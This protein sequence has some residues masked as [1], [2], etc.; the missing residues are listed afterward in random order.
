MNKTTELGNI[1]WVVWLGI[2]SSITAIITF[3]SGK[4]LP[5]FFAKEENATS[6]P[7]VLIVQPTSP[8]ITLSA[9]DFPMP[10]SVSTVTQSPFFDLTGVWNL[11]LEYEGYT[12][13][14]GIYKERD[15]PVLEKWVINL[16]Q[17]DNTLSGELVSVNSKYV[18]SCVNA[19]IDG[20]IKDTQVTMFVHFNGS[21]C[22]GEIARIDGHIQSNIFFSGGY[23][24]AKTP[25]G[26]CTISTGLVAGIKQ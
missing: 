23:Q 6:T 22:P 25:S 7:Y 17:S 3:L 10:T 8:A 12:N 13:S 11:D 2:L 26:T 15:T 1:K 4:N 21:C 14:S 20:S 19:S 5:D 18:D 9:A 16:L 24:P